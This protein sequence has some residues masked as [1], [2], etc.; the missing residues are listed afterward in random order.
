MR[1]ST[2]HRLCAPAT[3]AALALLAGC[4]APPS[5]TPVDRCPAALGA[6]VHHAGDIT[7]DETWRAE[8]GPHYVDAPVRVTGRAT[9]TVSPCAEVR[10]APGAGIDVGQGLGGDAARLVAEGDVEHPVRFIPAGAAPWGA[11]H[12]YAPA[13]LSLASAVIERGG[14]GDDAAVVATGRGT[15]PAAEV[16][17]VRDVRVTGARG[18]GVALRAAA[19]FSAGSRGLVISGSG[20]DVRPEP[21]S[22]G[23]NGIAGLPDGEYTGNA[24]D[25][26]EVIDDVANGSPGLQVD[27][28]LR[29][30]GVPY[31]L[32]SA[33]G[34]AIR[35]GASGRPLATFTVSAGV[36]LRMPD[37]GSLR[38]VSDVDG[39][40]GRL[41]VEGT[42]SR[43]VR[44][45]SSRATP[46]PG[47]WAG[48]YFESPMA[49]HDVRHARVEYA[50]G[51]CGCSLTSCSPL[52][53]FDAAVILDGPPAA[54]FVRES[55]IAHSAGH[56]FL[57]SWVDRDVDFA[58]MNDFDDVA[59]CAQ[60]APERSADVCPDPAYA[61][62][63]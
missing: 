15:T 56:G 55:T 42:A 11:L 54:A 9:L 22:V 4:G 18:H 1:R 51:D 49:D 24:A 52:A 62:A 43:P 40:R 3:A 8:S 20:D 27:A 12:A 36:T 14:A 46:R 29:D 35:V 57:R 63:P 13:T 33:P 58:A 19:R 37:G 2:P 21:L 45:T 61:C 47:D 32:R 28:T 7:A 39:P 30:L 50:G 17:S 41:R 38:A 53:R 31:A 44:F 60:T 26:V 23:L 48:L 16:I 6:G 59:G 34:E 10:L 25:Q 5:G